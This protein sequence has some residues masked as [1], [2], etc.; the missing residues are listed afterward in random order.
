MDEQLIRQQ[1]AVLL[2]AY[3]ELTGSKEIPG[4]EDFLKLRATAIREGGMSLRGDSDPTFIEKP[5]V[6]GSSTVSKAAPPLTQTNV[7][8]VEIPHVEQER[9]P[10]ID[11]Q[12]PSPDKTRKQVIEPE[13]PKEEEPFEETPSMSDAFAM[14]RSIQDPWNGQ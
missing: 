2:D 13:P 8:R 12:N 9:K 7:L 6:R 4:I 3:R 5:T 10:V 14:L 1:T 11:I